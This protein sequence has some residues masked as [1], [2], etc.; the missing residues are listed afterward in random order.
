[1]SKRIMKNLPV[2]IL[3]SLS[4]TT[5]FL[6]FGRPDETVFDEVHFGKFV[7]AYYTHNYYYDIHPPLGK[8]IIAGF[9]DLFDFRPEFAFQNIGDKFPDK[10]YLALRFLPALAG[11][12]FPLVIFYLA[13]RLGLSKKAAFAAGVFIIFENSL[14]SNSRLILLDSFL[15]L[16]GFLSV[17]FYLRYRQESGK[18]LVNLALFSLFAAFAASIKWTGLTFLALAGIYELVSIFRSRRYKKLGQ[19]FIFFAAIPLAIYFSVF[20]VHF[21]LL[22]KS[23]TGDAFMD[24]GFQKTLEG[25]YY[26]N[27]PNIKPYG[28][29]EKFIDLNKQMYLGN[30]R[31]T[32][33]HP[34]GSQWYEWPFMTRPIFLWVK[35]SARI[36]FMGNPAI[37]WASTVG[38]LMLA[39]GFATSKKERNFTSAF[40]LGGYALNLLPFIGIARVM[41]LYHYI[42]ALIFAILALAYVIDKEKE[43]RSKIIFG[44]LIALGIIA[45]IWFAPLT[46]GLPLSP[47]QYNGRVW[48]NSWE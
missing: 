5:H 11:S 47:E 9:A 19:A 35:D 37:W 21:S 44:V 41:F 14:V 18:A 28:L 22:S 7:S 25:S 12:L 34:Y 17:L 24:P 39:I 13:L 20:A 32:A 8:L 26:Y 30:K 15:Y 2:I 40:L 31:L 10:T 45:F 46:Y 33:T 43:K 27:D 3:L 38:V 48:F 6:F 23:G 36:Y 4:L 42:I 16:F 29:F 1:M